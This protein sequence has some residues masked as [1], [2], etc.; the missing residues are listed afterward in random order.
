[1]IAASIPGKCAAIPAPDWRI[2]TTM[3]YGLDAFA[4]YCIAEDN[5]GY[6]YVLGEIFKENVIISDAAKL[7]KEDSVSAMV[8]FGDFI[9]S[10]PNKKGHGKVQIRVELEAGAELSLSQQFDS[11]GTWVLVKKLTAAAKNL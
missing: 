8:E 5:R 11:N 1:M 2:Y 9:E 6:A 7:V 10:S 3:D 4:W